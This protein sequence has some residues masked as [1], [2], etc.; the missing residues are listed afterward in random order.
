MMAG[1]G[2]ATVGATAI[3]TPALAQSPVNK[4]PINVSGPLVAFVRDV[5]SGEVS[6]MVGEH[7][8]IVHDRELVMRLARI[9]S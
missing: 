6:V 7:E 2:A 9:A 8:V 1:A 5:G 3:A 4:G